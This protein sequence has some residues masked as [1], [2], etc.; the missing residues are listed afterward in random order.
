MSQIKINNAKKVFDETVVIPDLNVSIPE[1]SLVY[2]TG[3][4][5]LW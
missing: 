3:A 2:I 4:F 1:G 5:W